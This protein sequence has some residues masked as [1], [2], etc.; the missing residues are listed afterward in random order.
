MDSVSTLLISNSSSLVVS[1]GFC[2]VQESEEACLQKH[3]YLK[4]K[5][6]VFLKDYIQV[7]RGG[8]NIDA[9]RA[10]TGFHVRDKLVRTKK[11]NLT[12]VWN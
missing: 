9:K 4:V 11:E 12:S 6:Q 1:V 8:F 10:N 2:N 3:I 5:V 7:F